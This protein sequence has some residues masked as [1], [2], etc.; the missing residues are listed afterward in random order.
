M[1]ETNLD[2]IE[3]IELLEEDVWRD[4]IQNS[5]TE[6]VWMNDERFGVLMSIMA[7]LTISE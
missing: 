2:I 4:I 5:V 7:D 6:T 3:R 1:N